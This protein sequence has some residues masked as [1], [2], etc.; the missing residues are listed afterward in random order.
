MAPPKRRKLSATVADDKGA[1]QAAPDVSE[2]PKVGGIKKRAVMPVIVE[3]DDEVPQFPGELGA[4]IEAITKDGHYG[5]PFY[6]ASSKRSGAT[7]SPTGILA[8][9]LALGGGWSRGRA[10][11]LYGEKSSGKST[12]ALQSIAA[13][14]ARDPDAI[15][16]WIDTEGTFDHTWARK[17]GCDTDRIAVTEPETGEHAVD[18]ADAMLRAREV[19]I[20]CMDSIAMLAPM[21]ELDESVEQDTMALQARLVGKY[22]RKTNN[23][24]IKERG[25][26]RRHFPILIHLNQFRMKVGF[27]MGDPRVLPGGKAL[28]FSTSQQA[29]MKNKEHIGKDPDDNEVVLFNEHN[30]KITKNKAGGPMKEAAYKLIRLDGFEGM[31]EGWI[32]QAKT[33][34]KYGSQIGVI[35]GSAN[36]FTV[37]EVGKFKGAEDFTRWALEN[38]AA[39][40]VLQAKI[41]AGFRKRWDLS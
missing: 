1:A 23:A 40:Y 21:K 13:I 17:L 24:L 18:L 31:P 41:I 32:D 10:G 29:E 7:R 8:M 12:T 35:T 36:S 3:E 6:K 11:M 27:V 9:D 34:Y 22:I 5:T 4:M 19:A 39:Y 2:A 14:H 15:A 33:I 16:A 25:R 38:R 37:D 20:V 28:E 30:I 26:G